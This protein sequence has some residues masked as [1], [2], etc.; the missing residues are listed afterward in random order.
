MFID[1]DHEV[2]ILKKHEK[3]TLPYLKFWKCSKLNKL[4][5]KGFQSKLFSYVTNISVL[6]YWIIKTS[7]LKLSLKWHFPSINLIDIFI[8]YP[9]N[10]HYDTL[11][12][13]TVVV[14]RNCNIV[15]K[16]IERISPR[17]T[18]LVLNILLRQRVCGAG[19]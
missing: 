5:N 13:D 9:I 17:C 19:A 2:I 18:T 8:L 16:S 14:G 6:L 1:R 15:K 3:S 10:Y 7:P 12:V 4:F 11:P